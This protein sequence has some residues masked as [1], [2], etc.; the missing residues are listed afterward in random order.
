[1]PNII[2]YSDIVRMFD[3]L[4]QM[5]IK[6]LCRNLSRHTD[7]E[8]KEGFEWSAWQAEKLRGIR[9]FRRQNRK[10]LGDM[11]PVV[12]TETRAMLEE[13]YAE[14]E[15]LGGR[16]NFF[17]VNS[18]R[19]NKLIEDTQQLERRASS[20]DLRMMDDTYRATINRAQIAMATGSVTLP[21]ALDIAVKDF[22]EKGINCIQYRNG[23]RVNIA[24][25]AEMALRS[26]ATR[27]QLQGKSDAYNTRGHDTVIVSQY[28]GC[29]ETCLP[30]Q[31]RVYINDVWGK[32]PLDAPEQPEGKPLEPI[33]PEQ[34]APES[35]PQDV[36]GNVYDGLTDA[37]DSDILEESAE[38][39][40]SPADFD[41]DYAK[42]SFRQYIANIPE[43]YR[44]AL[45]DMLSSV[46]F[47]ETDSPDIIVA[48]HN[49]LDAVVYNPNHPRFKD[50]DINEA[51]IHELA[52]R[53][54]N[55]TARSW[56]NAWFTEA[57]QNAV[58]T[59][60]MRAEFLGTPELYDNPAL[61]DIISAVTGG[62][63]SLR[64]RFFHDPEYWKKTNAKAK[65]VF[66]NA[67]S[68]ES[69][70]SLTAKSFL[71]KIIPGISDFINSAVK[72]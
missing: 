58:F 67:F 1:M 2:S 46:G 34:S 62:D 55:L 11:L 27:A 25:Y 22:L 28:G 50:Y 8:K 39:P 30:W 51:L 66:V 26:A 40:E 31:G 59:D 29:S 42:E 36:S 65:E 56:E 9:E 32:Y 5:L 44:L 49:T 13:Q 57:I 72:G 7:W 37:G 23:R 10:I 35:V 68:L 43:K 18:K 53:Y 33:Q 52:H 69:K 6:S 64:L 61:S 48:Y 4:E 15:R 41:I 20:A 12:E 16:I 14:G 3:E 54:D 21:Q 60:E 70:Q 71:N 45:E 38:E 17:G 24:V 19:L 63:K 47:L